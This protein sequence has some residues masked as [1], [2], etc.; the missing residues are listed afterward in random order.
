MW[1]PDHVQWMKKRPTKA[2]ET[3]LFAQSPSPSLCWVT[4]TRAALRPDRGLRY[5]GCM[6]WGWGYSEEPLTGQ[7]GEYIGLL[8]VAIHRKQEWKL[9]GCQSLTKSWPLGVSRYRVVFWGLGHYS[10]IWWTSCSPQSSLLSDLLAS[11]ATA[12]RQCTGFLGY[13]AWMCLRVLFTYVACLCPLIV[14][15][16]RSADLWPGIFPVPHAWGLNPSVGGTS[17]PSKCK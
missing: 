12:H 13:E 10:V 6:G 16:G 2:R 4:R 11:W 14:D 9:G 1:L 5:I 15:M 17:I 7:A 8:Y 3:E